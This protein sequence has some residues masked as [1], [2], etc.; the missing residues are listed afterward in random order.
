MT[1]KPEGLRIS[2][3]FY[4]DE[5]EVDAASKRSSRTATAS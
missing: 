1:Q 5:R 3:H 4:N 2:T